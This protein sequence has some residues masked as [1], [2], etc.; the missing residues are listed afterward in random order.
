MFTKGKQISQR[1]ALAVLTLTMVSS[2]AMADDDGKEYKV[3]LSPLNSSGVYGEVEFKLRGNKLY[4][5]IE[6]YGLEVGKP[7]PQHIH[8]FNAPVKQSSCPGM[9]AD[10]NA[11]GIVSV[12]EGAPSYGPILL[13]LTPFDLV[14]ANG[15]LKYE[16]SFTINPSTVVPLEKRAVVLHGMTVNNQYIPSLPVACGRIGMDD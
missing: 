11:D 5:E 15:S 1:F 12:Q 16:A 3:N 2:Q 7:H 9:E 8:G 14:N 13:P 10:T 4:V 6:A